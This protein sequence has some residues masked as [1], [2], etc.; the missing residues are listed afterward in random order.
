LLYDLLRNIERVELFYRLRG[1]PTASR[2]RHLAQKMGFSSGK[3][4]SYKSLRAILRREEIIDNTG[5]FIENDPNIW[6]TKFSNYVPFERI[7]N[8]V[9]YRIPYQCFLAIM[10]SRTEYTSIYRLA[11]ELDLNLVSVYAAIRSLNRTIKTNPV[12]LNNSEPAVHLASWLMRY[13][14][15]TKEHAN[16]TDDSSKLFRAVPAYIDGL[17]ALQRVRYEPGMPIGPAPMIIR[18]YKPYLAFWEKIVSDVN[19][20]ANRT[21]PVTVELANK[22][23][24][25]T[26][27]SK[28]PYNRNPIV[29]MKQ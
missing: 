23:A 15:I 17:E 26:W 18:T 11:A 19:H 8:S 12:T 29:S 21:N 20:F 27:I 3:T 9:G 1:Q 28:L 22:S 5:R 24:K 2:K 13:L 7:S 6:L 16:I 14:D 25:V 4:R 10:L